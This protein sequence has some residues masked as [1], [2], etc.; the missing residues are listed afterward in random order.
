MSTLV[1]MHGLAID[2]TH[3]FSDHELVREMNVRIRAED[4]KHVKRNQTRAVL[5]SIRVK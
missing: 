4:R 3:L 5:D 1:H 2:Q